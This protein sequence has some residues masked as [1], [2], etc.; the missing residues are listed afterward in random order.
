MGVPSCEH[1]HSTT[2][3]QLV[4]AMRIKIQ[5]GNVKRYSSAFYP[6]TCIECGYEGDEGEPLGE[7]DGHKYYCDQCLSNYGLRA[8]IEIKG[9]PAQ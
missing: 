9:N 6:F 3:H 4:S 1:K 5:Q 7:I 2:A 8:N